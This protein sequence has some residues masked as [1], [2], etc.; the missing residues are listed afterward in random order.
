MRR[1][2]LLLAAALLIG[3]CG[4]SGASRSSS[5]KLRVVTTTTELTDF[6]TVVGGRDV[7]VY[8]V[9]KANVDPHDY[10]PSPADL[11]AIADADVILKNGVGIEKWLEKT[12]DSAS[13]DGAIVD[14][15]QGVTVRDHDPHI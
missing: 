9:L 15:S 13:P 4:T 2:A 14:T 3:A 6:A 1:T 5:D 10:E 12:L 7:D 8:G 11:E